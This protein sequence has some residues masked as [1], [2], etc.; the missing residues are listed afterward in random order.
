MKVYKKGEDSNLSTGTSLKGYVYATY[1][2]LVE[3]L[4]EPT[5]D[6]PSGDDKVQK[7]WVIK[8]AENIYTIYDWKTYDVEYTINNLDEWHIG[9][10][11][12]ASDFIEEL[13]KILSY[14]N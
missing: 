3:C 1:Q 12:Y 5:Y 14:P 7:Q 6:T 13:E 4:G 11:S 2:K 9:G 8:Y 10:S